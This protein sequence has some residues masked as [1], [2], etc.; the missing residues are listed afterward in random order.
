MGLG[1]AGEALIEGLA[2][3]T[4][5]ELAD[6]GYSSTDQECSQHFLV[7]D[8]NRDRRLSRKE[9]KTWFTQQVDDSALTIEGSLTSGQ[10]SKFFRVHYWPETLGARHEPT[11]KTQT[12]TYDEFCAA[13]GSVTLLGNAL[14]LSAWQP[15]V[16]DFSVPDDY[17]PASE[18]EP[19]LASSLGIEAADMTQFTED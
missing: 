16:D 6:H 3:A 2:L 15:P 13:F 17:T 5:Q 1:G 9:A 18:T 12:L 4:E 11:D 7:Y 8:S 10:A 19:P 14:D